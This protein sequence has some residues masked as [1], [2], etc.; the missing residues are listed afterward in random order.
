[1]ESYEKRKTMS[2]LKRI[3]LNEENRSQPV[4]FFVIPC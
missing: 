1:M 2:S 3:D 4:I